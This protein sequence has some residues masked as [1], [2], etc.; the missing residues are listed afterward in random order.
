MVVFLGSALINVQQGDWGGGIQS[1]S[2]IG[3]EKP[4]TYKPGPRYTSTGRGYVR[5]RFHRAVSPSTVN[6]GDWE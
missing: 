1:S 2:T 6:S 3:K 5:R 4:R